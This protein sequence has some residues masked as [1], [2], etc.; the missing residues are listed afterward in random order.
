M[1]RIKCADV[2]KMLR[3]A[4]CVATS[5]LSSHSHVPTMCA[6]PCTHTPHAHIRTH[7][8][9]HLQAHIQHMCTHMHTQAHRTCT[10]VHTHF[11]LKHCWHPAGAAH[12][13][14]CSQRKSL[15]L[16]GFIHF[17]FGSSRVRRSIYCVLL[18]ARHCTRDRCI[19]FQNS[20]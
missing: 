20:P 16:S 18:C 5:V 14:M 19:L 13:G 8:H 6:C 11:S 10:H 12:M 15:H 2:C 7:T 9:T 4:L 3:T 1:G 17:V